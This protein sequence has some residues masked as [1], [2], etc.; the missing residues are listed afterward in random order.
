MTL[1]TRVAALTGPDRAVDAEIAVACDLRPNWLVGQDGELWSD[2]G[3]VCW[4][5]AGMKKS[6]GNSSAFSPE[7]PLPAFTGSLDAAMTLADGTPAD[8]MRLLEDAVLACHKALRHP[9]EHLARYFTAAAL[10]AR[11]L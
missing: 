10:K 4:R 9:R 7:T 1:S 11:G 3:T 2:R 8:V 5:Y 6:S